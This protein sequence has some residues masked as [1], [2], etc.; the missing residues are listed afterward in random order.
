MH[1]A[2]TGLH[3]ECKWAEVTHVRFNIFSLQ[4]T[5]G[6]K[7]GSRLHL[8][9]SV[10][11]G[12]VHFRGIRS[13]HSQTKADLIQNCIFVFFWTTGPLDLT[14]DGPIFRVKE[15]VGGT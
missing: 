15:A 2:G 10:L 1:C 4:T 5:N 12:Q 11:V 9:T 7:V 6:R 3:D 8:E 13:R 14:S